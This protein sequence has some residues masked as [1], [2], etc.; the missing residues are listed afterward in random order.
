MLVYLELNE[1]LDIFSV[2][3]KGSTSLH[4][5]CYSG[6]EESVKYLISLKS[7]INALDKEK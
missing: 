7:D 6:S 1:P 5:A 3:E 2:D 4:W